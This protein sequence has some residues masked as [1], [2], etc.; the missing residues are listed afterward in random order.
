MRGLA[1]KK[2]P[3]KDLTQSREDAKKTREKI[4]GRSSRTINAEKYTIQ[5]EDGIQIHLFFSDRVFYLRLS[6]GFS[7]LLFLSALRL[8]GFA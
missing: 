2:K 4:E 1:G 6:C 7:S 8:C 3:E 5:S